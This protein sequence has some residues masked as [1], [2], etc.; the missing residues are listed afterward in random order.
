LFFHVEQRRFVVAEL[1]VGKS[2]AEY[3]AQMTNGLGARSPA[4]TCEV[5]GRSVLWFW[6]S[7]NRSSWWCRTQAIVCRISTTRSFQD[8]VDRDGQQSWAEGRGELDRALLKLDNE[9][10][11]V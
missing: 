6:P 11:R 8:R 1:K 10:S 4:P 9:D 2:T 5:R 7:A 3:A